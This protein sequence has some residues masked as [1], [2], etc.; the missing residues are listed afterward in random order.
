LP[1]GTGLTD[2]LFL[3]G[4]GMSLQSFDELPFNARPDSAPNLLRL[5]AGDIDRYLI[6]L[7][8]TCC[9]NEAPRRSSRKP[10]LM[11]KLCIHREQGTRKN[12]RAQKFPINPSILRNYLLRLQSGR[13]EATTSIALFDLAGGG[14]AWT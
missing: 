5:S 14:L 12:N 13:R 1:A 9:E 10:E 2:W 8:M 4:V 6:S 3:N 7:I 11:R